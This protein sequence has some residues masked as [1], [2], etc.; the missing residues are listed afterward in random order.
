MCLALRGVFAVVHL[1]GYAHLRAESSAAAR[2]KLHRV[3]V[4]GTRSLLD[5]AVRCGVRRFVQVSSVAAVTGGA[6]QIISEETAARPVSEYGKS[7]LAADRI[8]SERCQEAGIEYAILRPP[9]IYGPGMKG[10]PLRLFNLVNRGIPLPLA[11]VRNQRTLLYVGNFVDAVKS[12]LSGAL[13]QNGSYLAGDSESVSTPELIRAVA[14]ALGVRP[15]LVAVPESFLRLGARLGD[16]L[17]GRG[18][19][20]TSAQV[21]QL[22]GSLVL[23]SSR[24]T[25]ATGFRQRFS[26]ADGIGLTAAWYRAAVE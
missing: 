17:G 1:A 26:M 3:N 21:E 11:G 24:L 6:D 13:F 23:D 22:L 19:L 12:L 8:V 25:R 10:N 2:S 7:K 15:R 14:N 20:P 5:A 18:F 16:A 9:M 4:E